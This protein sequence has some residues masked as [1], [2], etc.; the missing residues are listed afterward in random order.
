[1][2]LEIEQTKNISACSQRKYLLCLFK[3]FQYNILK[4]LALNLAF[5]NDSRKCTL[6]TVESIMADNCC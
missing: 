2:T 4:H 3:I 5:N 1:M 6:H